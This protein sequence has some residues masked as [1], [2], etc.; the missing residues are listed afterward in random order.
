MQ[1]DSQEEWKPM[2]ASRR[3]SLTKLFASGYRS[4]KQSESGAANGIRESKPWSGRMARVWARRCFR[5]ALL[6]ALCVG[7]ALAVS[8]PVP[9]VDIVSPVSIHPGATGVT[10]QVYGTSFIASSVVK[11]NGTALTTTFVS[12]KKLTAAV[13]D[14]F[15]AAIGVGSITVVNPATL[16]SNVIFVPVAAHQ[17]STSFPATAS[18]TVSVGTTPQGLAVADFNG[19]G[20]PDMAVANY[21]ADTVTILLGNGN[22]T[23]TTASTP[24]AGAGANWV[25]TGDFNGDGKLDLAVANLLSSGSG[26]VSILLGDGT[27]H[28]TLGS[29]PNTGDGPFSLV[30]GDFNGDGKLDLAVSNSVGNSV[31]ILLGNGDGTFTSNATYGVGADPQ[32]IVAGDFNEDGI[33]DLAVANETDST[34]TI[35]LGTGTGSFNVQTAISTG[36]TLNPIG[37]IATD[38]NN[39]GHLDLAAVNAQDIGILLGNGNGTFANVSNTSTLGSFLIAGVTGDFNGDGNLDLVV[40]DQELGE[41]YLLL[42]NGNGT[43]NAPTSYPTDTGSFGAAT[44]DFNGDGGL[45]LAITNGGAANV[46]IFLQL[47]SVQLAPT[48]LTFGNQSVGTPSSEQNVVLTNGGSGTLTIDSVGFGGTDP[49]DYSEIDNC[50]PSVASHGTCTIQVTFTPTATGSRTALLTVTDSDSTSP[51]S[52][53]LSGTGTGGVPT[54]TYSPTSLTFAS[55]AVGTTSASMGTI[56]TNTSGTTLNVTSIAITGTNGGDFGQTNNCG[57]TVAGGGTCTISVTFSPTAIGS[58][59]AS[60][61]ITNNAVNS[62]ESVP[63]SG[64]A[65]QGTP[66]ITWAT[67]AAITYGTALSGTQLDATASVAGSFVYSPVSGTVLTAGAQTLSATFTPTDATDYTGGS[68]MVTLTVN[69][70]TPTITWA[71]PAAITYGTALSATQLDATA[72]VGGSFVYSPVSGTVQTAGPQNL[73]VT[74]TPTDMTDYNNATSNVT[75]TVNKATPTVT[76]ATPAAI[77][78]GTALSGTQL[79]ASANVGGS[80]VY[81]PAS[82]TVL[83]AGAQSLSVTFTPTDTTDYNNATGNVTL[84]VNKATPTI[85]WATPATITYGTALSGT[86]LNATASVAGS[87]VYTPASGTMLTAGVQSL[88]VAFTPTDTTDYNNVSGNVSLTVNKATPTVTWATPAA[89]TYGTALSGAQLNATAST[90]GS[91]VY[92]PASGTVLGAGAQ[93][94]SVAFTPTDTTDYNNASGN[95]TLTVNKA[96]PTVT[97]ATPAAITYGTALSATQLDATASTAGSFVYSPVSG[98]VL[99]AGAQTLSATFT[100]TDTTD[101]NNAT[102]NV[103]LTVNKATPTVT[104]ATPAAITYG[105]ALSGTQLDATASVP[106]SMVYTPA[107]GTV[108]TAGAQNLSVTFTPTD[109]TDYNNA[110]GNVTLTVNKA[111]PTITWTTPAAITYGTA[112]NATQLDAT[113]STAGSFVYAPASGT[114]LAAGAQTLSVTFTPTDTTDYNNATGNVTLT[115]NKATP[116]ITWATPAAITYGTALSA[117][118]LDATSSTAGAFVYTPVSGTVLTVG[119]QNLSATFTPTDTTDYN[120][121]TGNVTLTVNKATPTIN[122][123]T[124]AAITYGTALSATQ[125]DATSATAGSF[126]YSPASG[127]VLA[128]GSQTL[129]VTF[130]PTDGADYNTAN[131]NVTLIVNKATPTITWATPAAITYGTALSGV[132][133]N[134]T[135]IVQGSFAYLPVSG[136]V[137]GAGAQVLAVTLTPTDA[138]DY[139]NATAMVTLTVNKA[140]PAITWAT[141][142]AI[143]YPAAISATQLNAT[144]SVAGSFVYAPPAGTVLNAGVQTLA[145]TFTPTD[146]ADYSSATAMVI[147]TV[148]KA[149]PAVTWAAPAAITYGTAL[150]ATQLDA[151]ASTAGTFVYSPA[152]GAIIGVGA[153]NLSVTF[154]PTDTTDY[155]AA[156]AN[157]SITVN[158]AMPTITWATPAAIAYGTALGGAQ[159]DAS[160]S[161]AGAFVYTPGTGTVLNAGAQTLAVTFSPTDAT[162]NTTATDTVTISV[163]LAP[164]TT[165]IASSLLGAAPGETVTFTAKVTSSGGTPA[166]SVSFLDGPTL[167]GT[168]TLNSGSATFAGSFI[169]LGQ[170]SVTAMYGGS[171]NFSASTSSAVIE[172]IANPDFT[173]TPTSAGQTSATLV[174]GQAATIPLTFTTVGDFTGAVSFTISGL[175]TNTTVSFVP[176]TIMLSGN[177]GTDSMTIQTSARFGYLADTNTSPSTSRMLFAGIILF[178]FAGLVFMGATPMKK[179]NDKRRALLLVLVLLCGMSAGGC[180]VTSSPNVEKIGTPAG[181]YILTITGTSGATTHSIPFTLVV[182]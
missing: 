167:L 108:L 43:F 81:S 72:S 52:I 160:S 86:Q 154:T 35:L 172:A 34:V 131:A 119:A 96:T 150:S 87:F 173:M 156:T 102:G 174:A 99:T 105:T 77:T 64:T 4:S 69:K 114:V 79:D 38:F 80:F 89:I 82:G 63:L 36:G 37:L 161:T 44:A 10:L 51:Q 42:G 65:T 181:T 84:T 73:S 179:R 2:P 8:N 178:P 61:T 182:E 171:A 155:V 113:A 55:R 141:P 166:G 39:D 130:T 104:W 101:Y 3:H 129:S 60:I 148:N 56:L 6:F 162:D 163:T 137:L 48:S 94:L 152:A 74:F 100:P 28:F 58:R 24:S 135:S 144:A 95:A 66:V 88:S 115:V 68:G 151:T 169:T 91:F 54:V 132:Q 93:N 62:P 159:L 140:T 18:S 125:L 9:Y 138:T 133:L 149:A 85:T 21:G 47:L 118:Q 136:T 83:A 110:T 112:L 117:T 16:T 177:T 106:G 145:A 11:W 78:Y 14:S 46:S 146:T 57:A 107:S 126:V 122:W 23:F 70:A 180:G 124:P 116:T 1:D 90:A 41:A 142:P 157:V 121:A 139:N 13:P 123:A 22:G 103:T 75:L 128:A 111:T 127:T 170:H 59:S 153:Q 76:W 53:D 29:S 158:K 27:G 147:L 67:P 164:T 5:V 26:G 109:T 120:N 165:T 176:V 92:T 25:V 97:W 175:P 71:T 40:T 134:A 15:V 7:T 50:S 19:D 143:T 49:G 12:S 31:T 17:T 32:E 168:A 20:K 30:T 98:T 33:L 45:D